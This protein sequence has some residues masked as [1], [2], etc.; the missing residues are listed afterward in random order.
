MIE[1]LGNIPADR[2]DWQ[3]EPPAPS[4]RILGEHCYSWMVCDRQHI[5]ETDIDKHE[6]IPMPESQSELCTALAKEAEVWKNLILSLT[7]AQMNELRYQFGNREMNIR[8]FVGHILQNTIYKNGQISA[9]YFALGL[10]GTEP[11]EAPIPNPIYNQLKQCK[12]A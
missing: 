3:I 8:G 10:D 1:R 4:A 2:W 11:Y 5:L 7:P 6:L 9:I 12:N